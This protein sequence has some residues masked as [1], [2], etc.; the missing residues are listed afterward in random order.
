MKS[1]IDLSQ[2][3]KLPYHYLLFPPCECAAPACR[4]DL[5]PDSLFFIDLQIVQFDTKYL[6]KHIF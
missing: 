1:R 6:F 2:L 3:Q 4:V 5:F